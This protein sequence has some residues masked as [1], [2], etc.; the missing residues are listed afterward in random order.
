M[1]LVYL[2]KHASP[3]VQPNVPSNEWELS[4]QG[5]D[6]AKQL[7]LLARD[8]ELASIYSSTEPK[9]RATALLLADATGLTPRV[10][11]GFEEIRID[12]IANSDQYSGYIREVLEHP[13]AS[14]RGTERA[15]DAATRFAGAISIVDKGALPATVVAHGRVLTAYLT[16][17][18]G[19]EDPFAFWRAIAMPA[20]ACLDLDGPKLISGFQ[21]LPR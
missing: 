19:L 9:A 4:A 13:G 7:G 10:V 16:Q 17:L 12:W 3:A 8:W 18:V 15:A 1:R 21:A 2:I 11:E 20:W 5:I 6:E 14:L